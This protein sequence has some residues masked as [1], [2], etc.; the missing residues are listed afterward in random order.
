MKENMKQLALFFALKAIWIPFGTAFVLSSTPPLV[1]TKL[2]AA[3]P[4]AQFA[5]E[6]AKLF[7]NM[8]T[9]ASI[10]G[11][12]IVPI[13]FTAGLDFYGSKGESKFAKVLRR[14]FPFVCVA[15]FTS[16]LLAVIWA[17]VTVN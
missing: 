2:D 8:I 16:Q 6:A 7:G 15:G 14:I 11:G 17:S 12:A 1:D 10:M 4:L 5:P 13:G 9:P 3:P